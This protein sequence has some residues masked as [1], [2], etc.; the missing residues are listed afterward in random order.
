MNLCQEMLG[1]MKPCVIYDLNHA[2]N[3]LV[4]DDIKASSTKGGEQICLFYT[5][6]LHQ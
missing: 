3:S 2:E 4:G 1:T 5:G 6:I